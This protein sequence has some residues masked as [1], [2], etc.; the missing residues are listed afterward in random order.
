MTDDRHNAE[1]ARERYE[2]DQIKQL[3]LIVDQMRVCRDLL[4]DR[5]VPRAR[6]ALILIDNL[7]DVLM[8]RRC[9]A[10]F[11]ITAEPLM[12]RG[13]R[14]DRKTQDR[15]RASFGEKIR[16][17]RDFDRYAWGFDQQD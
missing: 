11:D 16:L 14:Y 4:A 9:Q 12:Y 3:L 7:V 6:M 17:I 2:Y 15:V 8:H 5:T 13:R 1:Q 10:I